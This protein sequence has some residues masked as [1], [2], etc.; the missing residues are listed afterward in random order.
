[1]LIKKIGICSSQWLSSE[2][3]FQLANQTPRQAVFSHPNSHKKEWSRA[4][5]GALD[6]PVMPCSGVLLPTRCQHYSSYKRYKHHLRFSTFFNMLFSTHSANN[7]AYQTSPQALLAL[8][9]RT[10][11]LLVANS[12]SVSHV[13]ISSR[14]LFPSLGLAHPTSWLLCQ[15]P[16]SPLEASC[17]SCCKANNLK[18]LTGITQ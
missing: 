16:L 6:S 13:L 1:M 18:T 5:G 11:V 14:G 7:L 10:Q 17:I 4:I 9:N 12:E 15:A 8:S 2:G 3:S